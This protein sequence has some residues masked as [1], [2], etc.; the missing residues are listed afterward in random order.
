MPGNYYSIGY[1][2]KVT[3]KLTH[4]QYGKGRTTPAY[5]TVTTHFVL[6]LPVRLNF[7][8]PYIN[9]PQA[10]IESFEIALDTD[11]SDSSLAGQVS[12]S[13]HNYNTIGVQG[14]IVASLLQ[15]TWCGLP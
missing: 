6:I 4:V 7:P 5:L 14:N 12:L 1:W 13:I 10:A 3:A 2:M 8:R 9:D 15:T 11:P